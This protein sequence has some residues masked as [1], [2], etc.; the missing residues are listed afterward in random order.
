MTDAPRLRVSTVIRRELTYRRN[1]ADW[2]V[3]ARLTVGT[4]WAATLRL[5]DR[6]RRLMAVS[7]SVA[8]PPAIDTPAVW[9]VAAQRIAGV[10]I[11]SASWVMGRPRGAAHRCPWREGLRSP[12]SRRE[13]T[14]A[15]LT[16]R[17]A[18][19]CWGRNDDGELGDGTSTSRRAPVP[20]TG[21]LTFSHLAAGLTHTCGLTQDGRAYCWGDNH[22][23]ELGRATQSN[24]GVP[25][26]VVRSP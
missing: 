6:P 22:W 24:V 20:V 26:P 13:G 21:G 1:G 11:S 23:G 9:L 2:P 17:G 15:A 19:Y 5:S 14:P 16:S 8:S 18:A 3:A 12:A 10:W 7:R 25:T 4:S